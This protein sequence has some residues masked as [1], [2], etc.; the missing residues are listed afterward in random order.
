MAGQ[1]N[2][3][4]KIFFFASLIVFLNI[5]NAQTYFVRNIDELNAANKKAKPG[6]VILLEDGEWKNVKIV[7][8]CSGTKD[9][10]VIFKAKNAS[11]VLIT[12]NSSLKLGGDF[13]VVDGLY[14]T[15]GYAGKDA[16]IDFKI[17]KGR[18]A[19]NCRVTNCVV[20]DFNNPGRMEENNWV[21][22]SGQNNRLDHCSFMNKKNMGVLLAVLLDD[23][24]SRTNFHSIDHNYFGIRPPLA[25]NGGEII[26]VGVSQ[27]CE[28][29]SNTSIVNNFFEKCD[30]ETEIISIKSGSNI[31]RNNLFYE[32][33]G[34]VVLRHGNDNIVESNIFVGNG[35]EGTG[36]VRIIN[37][38]Q[39]VV[40][41]LFYK[42]RGVDFRSP[43]S[44]MNGVPNSPAHRYVQVTD[45]VIANNSFFECSPIS[46]CEGSDK[47]RSLP[48]S[49]VIF[50]NNNFYNHTDPAIYKAYDN[51]GGFVFMN[52]KVSH[53]VSQ[54]LPKGFDRSQF[55][56]EKLDY[57]SIPVA[58][59]TTATVPDSLQKAAN[60][61]LQRNLVNTPGFDGVKF[62]TFIRSTAY[63]ETGANWFE[64]RLSTRKSASEYMVD[65]PYADDIYKAVAGDESVVI[66]L[67]APSYT[68][69]KPVVI[70]KNVTFITNNNNTPVV[71]NSGKIPAVFMIAGKGKLML[72]DIK[73]DGSGVRAKH[74]VSSDTIGSSEHY[75]FEMKK[76]IVYNLD[77]KNGCEDLFYAYKSMIADSIVLRNNNFSGNNINYVMMNEERDDKGYY[78]AEKIVVQ[79]NSFSKENGS[80]LDVYRGGNDESTMGPLILVLG[81]KFTDVAAPSDQ[82]FIQFT[83]AQKTFIDKNSFEN[84]FTGKKLLVYKDIV[85]ADHRL[86][87]NT[88]RKSGEV[89]KNNYVVEKETTRN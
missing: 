47:E 37:R 5:A 41:N 10:P 27:H 64:R 35:K 72:Q 77:R 6:D 38:G 33:Q 9:K 8:N 75:N 55:Q 24:R 67:I 70:G 78:N 66:R 12:G 16:V 32:C 65:C 13:I 63:N 79:N 34:G 25:S 89:F 7:L 36:G 85:R 23:D 42:C 40:N 81:N 20:N 54:Q 57:V 76:C 60:K 53:A 22:F 86:T 43:M 80:L 45:A 48:P 87:S 51:I 19:N 30:G 74:F 29:N 17:D 56:V 31:V 69:D 52:N 68:F 73:I 46:L 21:L 59:A 62:A 39:W 2:I 44:I 71:F 26:R 4:K 18:L 3:M 82:P 61:R 1:N 83:G 50:I 58:S 88:M 11:R 49:N 84:C 14:F 15:N 28:F